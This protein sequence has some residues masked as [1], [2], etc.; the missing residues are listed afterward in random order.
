MTVGDEAFKGCTSL[1]LLSVSPKTA[2]IGVSAYE[3]CTMLLM[4]QLRET[5]I[6]S[7]KA[8]KGCTKLQYLAIG[9]SEGATVESEALFGCPNLRTIKITDHGVPT[10]TNDIMEDYTYTNV[11]IDPNYVA[12]LKQSPIWSKFTHFNTAEHFAQCPMPVITTVNGKQVFTCPELEGVEFKCELQN[13]ELVDGKFV[14]PEEIIVYV[15]TT[16]VDF[17]DSEPVPFT[18]Q[19]SDINNDGKV[20]IVDIAAMIKKLAN[21]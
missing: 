6:I 1:Q 9:G 11:I 4:A 20:S 2:S 16:K 3:G 14:I 21:Q 12:D 10:S 19:R 17:E 18:I 5:Y 7:E 15:R 13:L 8:F